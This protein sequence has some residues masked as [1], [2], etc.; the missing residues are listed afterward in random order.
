M[1]EQILLR[2]FHK[3][4]K[5]DFEDLSVR[6]CHLIID[7][8]HMKAPRVPSPQVES[9]DD[10]LIGDADH[11]KGHG[12]IPQPYNVIIIELVEVRNPML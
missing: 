1:L 2:V 3:V 5:A 10:G 7:V 11:L 12:P 8:D 6:G 9:L 4:S